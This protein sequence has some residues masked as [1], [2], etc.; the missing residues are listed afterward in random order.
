MRAFVGCY[1]KRVHGLL[2]LIFGAFYK[3]GAVGIFHT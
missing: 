1:A 2:N 3:S